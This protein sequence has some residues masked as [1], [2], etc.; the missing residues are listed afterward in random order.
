MDLDKEALDAIHELRDI[1]DIEYSDIPEMDMYMDQLLLFLNKRLE[2]H[3]RDANGKALTKPMINNYTK[4]QLLLPPK[5]KKYNKEHIL[6]LALVFQLKNILSIGDIQHLFG[7]ML[8]DMSTPDDDVMPMK[9]IYACYLDLKSAYWEE[10]NNH[11][12]DITEFIRKRTDAIEPDRNRQTAELFLLVLTLS[13]QSIAAKRM[14]ENIIDRYFSGESQ[15][16]GT[17]AM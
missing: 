12:T 14:A 16:S 13:A 9:D 7:P 1:E 15:A 17:L 3:K 10:F 8:K 4:L 11:L 5:N 2:Q 6:L